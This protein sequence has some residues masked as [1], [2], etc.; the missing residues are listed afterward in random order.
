[1]NAR[2]SRRSRPMSAV[3]L[4][5]ALGVVCL[6]GASH[7]IGETRPHVAVVEELVQLLDARPD[8]KQAL[9]RAIETA[10]LA[11]IGDLD[12]FLAYLDGLVTFIPTAQEAG[13]TALP[14]YYVVNQAPDDGLNRDGSFAAWMHRLVDA[15]GAFLD[16][17][18]SAAGIDS[19]IAS[20]SFR[21]DD[22]FAGPSGWL[23][24]NQFFAR[25]V[26]PGRRPI[27]RPHDDRVIVS[28][29]DSV[30][31][32]Q[33]PIEDDS[34]VTVK[35]VEWAVADLLDGSPYQDAFQDGTFT[36]SFLSVAD[37]HRYHV[38]VAGR[39]EEVRNIHG[40]VYMD[41][42][43]RPD[44]SLG[45][46]AGETYQ[47]GQERGLIV[48]DSP[49]VGLVAVLPVGMSFVSSVTLTP[50]V[51]AWLEKG[52]EFGF[53]QFGGSDMVMLFQEGRVTLDAE[54]GTKYLQ[55]Q[56]IGHAR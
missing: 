29:A 56:R 38:P 1:M 12:A 17:P 4:A 16:T 11:G 13:P 10:D 21:I 30:Y 49:A 44:G 14:L 20:P 47:V 25:E 2:Q 53:F 23:T 50:D 8:L 40:R 35:G 43:R 51:G 26:K 45:G 24:F 54:V 39:I 6:L 28:P 52:D 34:R 19:F 41:V 3:V 37:Y 22:Y 46:V 27:A 33:W 18:E 15:W 31:L 32:G 55:G 9:E 42:V 5:L 36:H 48:I 7:A